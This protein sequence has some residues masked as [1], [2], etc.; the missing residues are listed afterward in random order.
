M[1]EELYMRL[2][3]RL[4]Q[5]QV[6]MLLVEP[7]L[8]LLRQIYSREEAELAAGFP[9]GFYSASELASI[10]GRDEKS[11]TIL[12]EQM[13]NRGLLFTTKAPEGL[14]YALTPFVPGVVEFQLMRGNDTP[15]DR[16]IAKLFEEFMEGDMKELMR[17][18]L[19]D[20]QLARQLIPNAPARTITVQAALPQSSTIYPFEKLSEARR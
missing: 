2:G 9:M 3:E 8:N 10:F 20:P 4:N 11:L 13:A 19:A 15:Q 17:T 6:K 1:T 7:L 5:Y 16:R 18:A 12:L 14:R